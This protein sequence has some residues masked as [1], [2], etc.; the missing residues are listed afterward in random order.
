[1]LS[2]FHL[3]PERHGYGQTD[4]WTEL[5]YQYHASACWR[6]IKMVG[7]IDSTLLE[8]CSS[9]TKCLTHKT[10]A[11]CINGY[12]SSTWC[13]S[14]CSISA[15]YCF[16][17]VVISDSAEGTLRDTLDGTFVG[18][19]DNKLCGTLGADDSGW[20]TPTGSSSFLTDD[21]VAGFNINSNYNTLHYI[22]I[23][24]SGL[25]RKLQSPLWQLNNDV[26]ITESVYDGKVT[27]L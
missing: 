22:K 19:L 21:F 23:L 26:R 24:Y 16:C 3:L 18:T 8:I 5:L 6:A 2:C 4:R 12:N 25:S 11:Q 17:N 13:L 15:S 14:C 7:D 27:V 1:M 9:S 20:W 10:V